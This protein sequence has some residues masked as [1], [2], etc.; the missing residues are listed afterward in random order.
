MS[1]TTQAELYRVVERSAVPEVFEQIRRGEQLEAV[2]ALTPRPGET[3]PAI[4]PA[5]IRTIV[6]DRASVLFLPTSSLVRKL[7][8]LLGPKLAPRPGGAARIWWPPARRGCDP[9]E[10]PLIVDP[11]GAYGEAMLAI[12]AEQFASTRPVTRQRVGLLERRLDEADDRV[13]ELETLLAQ[14]IVRADAAEAALEA[15]PR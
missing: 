3:L 5:G 14:A 15:R 12:F 6:G 9:G 8:A 11:T 13:A 7:A 4:P 1:G 10:H 2:V